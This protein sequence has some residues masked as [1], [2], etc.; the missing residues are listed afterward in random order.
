MLMVFSEMNRSTRIKPTI[1]QC[2]HKCAIRIGA[3][4]VRCH[5][6]YAAC[7]CSRYVNSNI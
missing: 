3:E 5:S 6:E 2:F 4:A 7:G 1:I